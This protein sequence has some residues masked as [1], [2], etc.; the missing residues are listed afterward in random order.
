M[1]ARRKIFN[2]N[3]KKYYVTSDGFVEFESKKRVKAFDNG[4]G[5]KVVTLHS[6]G[7]RKNFYIHRLVAI[8]FLDNPYNLPEVNHINGKKKDNRVE[9]LEWVSRKR[10]VQHALEKGLTPSGSKNFHANLTSEQARLVFKAYHAGI[11]SI[12][13]MEAFNISRHT[14]LDIA[15]KATYKLETKDLN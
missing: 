1:T 2:F 6:N 11:P 14:V 8:C 3:N 7:K 4:R 12:E 15:K 13:I 9:N 5:Y 10:N